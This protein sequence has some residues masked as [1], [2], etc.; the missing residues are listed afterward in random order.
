MSVKQTIP[1]SR[2]VGRIVSS[3]PPLEGRAGKVRLDFNE[4][5]V[6]CSPAVVR[7]LAGLA[8]ERLATYPEY[9]AARARLARHFG[10]RPG[11]ITLTNGIDEGLR[12]LVDAYVDPGDTLL[13]VEP[14]F[15]MYRFYA[16]MR[17]AHVF[18]LRHDGEMCF[19]LPDVLRVLGREV[20]MPRRPKAF[21]LANPN[22]PTGTLVP[23]ADVRRILEAAARTL[24]LVDEAYFDFSGVTVLPWIRRYPN[25]VVARTFSKAMGLAGLRLGC[26]F[27]QPQIIGA[28]QRAASPFPV[29][30]AAL[31]AADAALR[32]L[33]FVRRYVREVSRSR[34]E[35]ELGLA[36]L[37]IRSFPT[38]A[39]FLLA[40]FGCRGPAILRRLA[41]QNILLRDRSSDFGRVGYVRV[42]IGTRAQTGQLL[43]AMGKLW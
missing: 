42:T 25:L 36:R 17:G 16:A 19:P 13:T 31:V 4:N 8:P 22:N 33:A 34:A 6:G 23:A 7:A 40:D 10:V 21:F 30:S 18:S 38:A 9:E 5:T 32:D 41:R 39:N 43:R 12:L 37:G 14:T 11:E 1:F 29:N 35:L 15:T 24:V 27:A 2:A 3:P 26:L 28:I 20:R